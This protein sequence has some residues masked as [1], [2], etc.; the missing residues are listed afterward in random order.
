MSKSTGNF[1]TVRE[2]T[3]EYDP[4][5]IRFFLLGVH[6]R[7]PINFSREII[8]SCK[9]GLERI[10]T[11]VEQIKYL[12]NMK[13]MK[14]KAY[15]QMSVEEEELLSKFDEYQVKFEEVMDDDFNTADAVTCVFEMVR[16]ANTN[17]TIDNSNAFL[18]KVLAKITTLCD[19]L[20]IETSKK[21]EILE[22]E[23]EQLIQDRQDARKAKNFARADEIRN[24]LLEK[25]IVLEDTREGVKWKRA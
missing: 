6:Y 7:S 2:I 10:Q 9:N 19:I 23:I 21:E 1:F 20:G 25:G 5:V 15:E 13:E 16:L 22:E 3:N 17:L 4:A 11:A 8:E 12:I 14:T 18:E 24:L